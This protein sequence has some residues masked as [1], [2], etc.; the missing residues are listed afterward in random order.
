MDWTANVAVHESASPSILRERILSA[1][2]QGRVHPHLLYSGLRQ[3]SL[4]M[5]LHR[6]FSPAQRDEK[7]VAM[8]DAA[9][10]TAVAQSRGNVA[11]V[12]SL[13]CGD[14]SKDVRCLN[15]VR[16][17][18][19]AA[20]YTPVDLS[21]D[22][23]LTAASSASSELR[24]LQITPL[25]CDLPHCSVLPAILKGFDPSGAERILLFLGTIHNYWPPEILKSIL[26]PLRS[27]DQLLLSA[28]LASAGNYDDALRQI[29]LQYDNELTRRWL[30]GAL[31]E[32][33]L[34]EGDGELSF[35]IE[36]SPLPTLE[37][38][39]ATFEL[40]R[41]VT[42]RLLETELSIQRGSRLVVFFSHR[43]TVAQIER[44]LVDA[45]LRITGKWVDQAESEGLFLCQRAAVGQQG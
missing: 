10:Q 35:Q 7:C 4:W 16:D 43:F 23:A 29:I 13:A 34:A 18:D 41:T 22:L 38:I 39:E 12:V 3:T 24:G 1:L 9:F 25:L 42:V 17:S 33:G 21:L 45:G 5:A 11:H 27:Q 44:F 40:K 6:A 28:N 14:G 19:R 15:Q 26:Y 8:Y 31:S 30:M 37:R 20:L 2:R 36:S 32:L